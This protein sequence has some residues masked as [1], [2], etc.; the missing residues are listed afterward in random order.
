MKAS[1]DV[2]T[3]KSPRHSAFVKWGKDLNLLGRNEKTQVALCLHSRVFFFLLLLAF[4]LLRL[5]VMRDL[6]MRRSWTW[7]K[8]EGNQ[9]C[10]I[11]RLKSSNSTTVIVLLEYRF[12][13]LEKS[14]VTGRTLKSIRFISKPSHCKGLNA[15]S[16]R[17]GGSEELNNPLATS[18]PAAGADPWVSFSAAAWWSC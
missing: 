8:D 2:P 17:T 13:S 6:D 11:Q 7:K 12:C 18:Q 16:W 5:N 3:S 14:S 1:V 9:K 15:G 10:M 4:Y